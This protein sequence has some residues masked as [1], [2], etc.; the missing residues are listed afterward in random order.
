LLKGVDTVV[1]FNED[2]KKWLNGF[3][4]KVLVSP[5]GLP[6]KVI[7]KKFVSDYYDHFLFM[8]GSGHKPNSSGLKWF[9]DE[10]YLPHIE[11]IKW[12]IYI[13]GIWS[14][15]FRKKYKKFKQINFI[16][17]VDDL[18]PIFDNGIMITPLFSGSGIRTK[19][20]H[21]FINNVPVIST[22]FASQGLYDEHSPIDHICLFNNSQEFMGIFAKINE[23]PEY[24]KKTCESA[25]DY[26]NSNFS[27]NK[28]VQM[29]LK[30]YNIDG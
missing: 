6:E 1:V 11:K 29:R 15:E 16:G 12:P 21:A 20:L 4:N 19:I 30:A 5:F 3:H 2:D 13:T 17:L 27:I 10:V 26:Y 22:P 9:F 23:D 7:F 18:S 14:E 28:I 8:G 25:I 24:L